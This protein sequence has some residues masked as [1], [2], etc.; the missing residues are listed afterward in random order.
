[1]L[2]KSSKTSSTANRSEPKIIGHAILASPSGARSAGLFE[3][4]KGGSKLA[5][6][7]A[8]V[9]LEPT[10]NF[11]YALWLSN[12]AGK[13]RPLNRAPSVGSNGRIVGGALLPT[14]AAAYNEVL[15]TRETQTSSV[16]TTPGETIL[17]GKIQ[18]AR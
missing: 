6:Y 17:K 4:L 10:S 2:G 12:G 1:V 13:S 3:V 15:L 11:Y 14:N 5:Y 18:Y 8:A 16:P 7:I 9:G